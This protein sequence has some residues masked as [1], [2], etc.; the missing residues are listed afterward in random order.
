KLPL[1]TLW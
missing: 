1:P